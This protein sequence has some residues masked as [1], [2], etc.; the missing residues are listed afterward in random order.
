MH[1]HMRARM[2]C[3]CT[4]AHDVYMNMYPAPA[5]RYALRANESWLRAAPNPHVPGRTSYQSYY[6]ASSLS[7]GLVFECRRCYKELRQ[8]AA[9]FEASAT[10]PH[11]LTV[12]LEELEAEYDATTRRM[13]LFGGMLGSDGVR[14]WPRFERLLGSTRRHDLSRRAPNAGN[15][16]IVHVS[17]SSQKAAM[18]ALLL[19]ES[20]G[21]ATEL[22]VLRVR[23]GYTD[24]PGAVESYAAR[25]RRWMLQ[26]L[27]C[28]G[29]NALST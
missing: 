15:R 4:C 20:H 6:R 11:V 2:T 26:S 25:R 1:M 19:D 7:E 22:N 14:S 23:L 3:T 17:N 10:L 16:E 24:Q 5:C 12:R 18:R 27:C 28:N 29:G 8:A 21:V 9:L 13:L